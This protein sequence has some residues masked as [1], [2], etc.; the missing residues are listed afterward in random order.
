MGKNPD[1]LVKT[2][3]PIEYAEKGKRV[4]LS[5]KRAA[6]GSISVMKRCDSPVPYTWASM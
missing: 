6:A 1:A 5:E 4:D 2:D 3:P